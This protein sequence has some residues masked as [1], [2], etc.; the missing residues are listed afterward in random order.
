MNMLDILVDV[1]MY[2]VDHARL[3]YTSDV[4]SSGTNHVA[5]WLRGRLKDSNGAYRA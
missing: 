5:S 3:L 1:L 2:L 4:V